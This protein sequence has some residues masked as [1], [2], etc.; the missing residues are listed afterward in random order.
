LARPET[1]SKIVGFFVSCG[2][3]AGSVY[4]FLPTFW[5]QKVGSWLEKN[6]I[7]TNHY[8]IAEHGVILVR[9]IQSPDFVP[10]VTMIQNI[11]LNADDS[12]Q[13][14]EIDLRNL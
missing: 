14:I 6:K 9:K 3:S 11:I 2:T 5:P 1:E 4:Y 12:E 10:H 7:L 8:S 13:I